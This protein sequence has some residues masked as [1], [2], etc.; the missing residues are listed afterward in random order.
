MGVRDRIPS[1]CEEDVVLAAA[2]CVGAVP[3]R[4]G[5]GRRDSPVLEARE[6]PQ[7]ANQE[8]VKLENPSRATVQQLQ[9]M[10]MGEFVGIWRRGRDPDA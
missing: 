5:P 6:D 7:R 10:V 2:R 4:E 1:R 3:K 9:G 8:L